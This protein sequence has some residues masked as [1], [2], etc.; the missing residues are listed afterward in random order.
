MKSHG[1]I[2]LQQLLGAGVSLEKAVHI[3]FN[4]GD[5][6][7]IFRKWQ[8]RPSLGWLVAR[9]FPWWCAFPFSTTMIP[10]DSYAFVSICCGYK[11]FRLRQCHEVIKTLTYPLFLV[12][13]ALGTLMASVFL[14]HLWG[15]A[16][17]DRS[18]VLYGL[19]GYSL[20][21]VVGIGGIFRYTLHTKPLDIIYIVRECLAKGWSMHALF[22]DVV[23]PGGHHK[24]WGQLQ[25]LTVDYQSFVRAF[26]H[27]FG[28]PSV[29][30]A[31]LKAAEDSEN[32]V[33]GMEQVIPVYELHY[34]RIVRR[35]AMGI[36][37]LVYVFLVICIVYTI[38]C[39]YEPMDGMSRRLVNNLS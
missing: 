2:Y 8:G 5:T 21:L 35:L 23:L 25:Q 19:M 20:G 28:V 34:S 1:L 24:K 9:A 4:E 10:I 14:G 6:T 27:V 33:K 22:R 15:A 39:M 13:M 38:Q 36:T 11:A 29:I 37:V 17:V 30:A 26:C 3:I 31:I 12:I 7:A 18:I 32:T 16:R